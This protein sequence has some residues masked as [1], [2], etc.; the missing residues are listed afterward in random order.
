[1]RTTKLHFSPTEPSGKFRIF[2]TIQR[3]HS[4]N[5]RY[6]QSGFPTISGFTSS[7]HRFMTLYNLIKSFQYVG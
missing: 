2:D 4:Y 5:Q 7:F 6:S 1:M 3:Y